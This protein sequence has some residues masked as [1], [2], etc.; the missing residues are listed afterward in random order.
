MIKQNLKKIL[1]I[2]NY[3][4]KDMPNWKNLLDSKEKYNFEKKYKNKK[5]LIAISSGGHKLATSLES[6]IG[7]ALSLQGAEVEFLLCDK[8]LKGC[9]MTTTKNTSED[10]IINGKNLNIC[11]DCFYVGNHTFKKTGLKILKFSSFIDKAK[12]IEIKKLTEKL[13]SEEILDYHINKINIGEQAK[14]GI[15]RYYAVG[16]LDIEKNSKKMLKRYFESALYTYF[17]A[18][19][20]LEKNKYDIVLL[21]HGIYVPQGIIFELTKQKKINLVTWSLGARNNTYIFSHDQTYNKDIVDESISNWKNI[22]INSIENKIDY[23][24]ESK[25]FGDQDWKSH[26]NNVEI[27]VE[28]FFKTKNIDKSIPMVGL[29]TNVIWDAQLHYDDTIFKNMLEWVF[30]SIEYFLKRPDINLLIRVHPTEVK[31]D[32]P[33]RQKVKDEIIKYFKKLPKNIIIIDSDENISTYKILNYCNCILVYGTKL[34]AELCA[35]GFPVILAGEAII[36]NKGFAMEP[37]NEKEYFDILKKLPIKEKM[38]KQNINEAKKFAY[39][40]YFKRMLEI[41]SL[42]AIPFSFPPVKVK[43]D[44]LKNFYQ[45]ND[46]KLDLIC[47]SIMN[48]KQFININSDE[49]N[50]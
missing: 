33:S 17:S 38:D 21:N 36:R 16:N 11:D 43:K 32:R 45:G 8:V 34:G 40:Y 9:I 7:V 35:K 20:L 2:F 4:P 26:K 24:L 12:I 29:T 14:A 6:L 13:S 27:D 49:K 22:D 10:K 18:K 39:Y 25:V 15:L 50:H 1:K 44:F 30:K 41:N 3:H 28:K 37:K 46:K 23:Y 31:S 19:N 48:K 5:I 42:E 47:D